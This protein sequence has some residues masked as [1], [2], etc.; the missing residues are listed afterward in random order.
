[1]NKAELIEA[2][3]SGAGVTKQEAE[4]VIGAFFDTVRGA[5]RSGDKVSW[6]GFGSFSLAQRKAR[7]GVNPQ[8]GDKVKIGA[9]KAVKFTQGS[10]LKEYINSPARKAPAKK[11]R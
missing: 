4:G 7:M 8:T 9:S 10:A 11:A 1:M 5:V 6:P 2:V 3:A